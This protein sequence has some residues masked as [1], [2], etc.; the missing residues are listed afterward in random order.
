MLIAL[1]RALV[2]NA[3]RPRARGKICGARAIR[4]PDPWEPAMCAPP[5]QRRCH[6]VVV[7]VWPMSRGGSA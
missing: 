5:R 7:F 3:R 1:L 2:D 6:R 4:S